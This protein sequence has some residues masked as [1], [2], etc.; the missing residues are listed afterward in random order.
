[1]GIYTRLKRKK[2]NKLHLTTLILLTI[3][4]GC[5]QAK[6]QKSANKSSVQKDTTT[7]ITSNS[8]DSDS[9]TQIECVRQGATPII[10][11]DIFPNSDFKLQS[12]KITGIETVD[13]TNGDK[14]IIKNWGCEYY[15]LTFRFETSRFQK[16]TTNLPFWFKKSVLLMSEIFKGLD[17]PIDIKKGTVSLVNYID[18]D[19]L[20]NYEN[21]KL[22]DEIDFGGKDIRN[23]VSLDKIQK[24]DNNKYAIEISFVMGPL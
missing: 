11:K 20:N 19:Q 18:E 15:C 16:D 5:N 21:L 22:G 2:M 1:M 17:S 10:K 9:N 23:Y 24:I 4:L 7:E 12:D 6:S 14:L 3:F 8:I 13:F